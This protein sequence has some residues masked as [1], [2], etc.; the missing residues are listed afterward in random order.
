L[1][2]GAAPFLPTNQRDLDPDGQDNDNPRQEPGM[3]TSHAV[4][5][6]LAASRPLLGAVAVLGPSA[7]QRTRKSPALKAKIRDQLVQKCARFLVDRRPPEELAA[8]W[9]AQLGDDPAAAKRM[10]DDTDR[11]MRRARWDDM[12]AWK[13]QRG[14]AA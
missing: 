1:W 11:R 7:C 13:H 5:P 2:K 4:S 9:A 10:L 6:G 14:I 3:D 12:R 8:Y